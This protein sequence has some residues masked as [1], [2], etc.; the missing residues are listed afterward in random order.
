MT[1][2]PECRSPDA[3]PD[4]LIPLDEDASP[5]QAGG[6]RLAAGVVRIPRGK[7][8]SEVLRSAN[9]AVER[10]LAR[11]RDVLAWLGGDRCRPVPS[12]PCERSGN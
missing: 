4:I 10:A 12:P 8:V 6:A 3:A 1:S 11:K 9:A 5:F 2:A 7:P